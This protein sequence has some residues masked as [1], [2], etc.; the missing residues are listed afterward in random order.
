M[1]I[2]VLAKHI[3]D[4]ARSN[5]VKIKKYV[6]LQGDPRTLQAYSNDEERWIEIPAVKSRVSYAIA[7]HELG[8]IL[9]P[10]QDRSLIEREAGAWKWARAHALV[11]SKAMDVTMHKGLQSYLDVAL[12]ESRNLSKKP[13][14]LPDSDHY[15]WSCLPP[16]SPS[17]AWLD[18]KLHVVPWRDVFSHPDRPRCELCI[19]WSRLKDSVAGMCE[20]PAKRLGHLTPKEAFCGS[21]QFD[22]RAGC[23]RVSP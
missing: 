19:F 2:K 1:H 4:T 20:H 3:R 15:F 8:H 23:G 6:R 5:A 16:M 7:L 21:Y 13:I 14:K 12:L 18:H 11:W 17:P 22:A 10:W 9:G